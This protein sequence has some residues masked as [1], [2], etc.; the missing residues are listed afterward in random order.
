MNAA[1]ANSDTRSVMSGMSAYTDVSLDSQIREKAK[2]IL[3]VSDAANE[4]SQ[5]LEVI[6][7]QDEDAASKTVEQYKLTKKG[8]I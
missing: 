3:E 8:L 4:A 1:S 2:R 7:E 5:K 6:N